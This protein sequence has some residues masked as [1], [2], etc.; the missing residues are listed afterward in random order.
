MQG[1]LYEAGAA[2]QKASSA[3]APAP[4]PLVTELTFFASIA[5]L[6]QA[7]SANDVDS[8]TPHLT[9]VRAGLN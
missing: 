6:Y 7:Q 5:N 4:V 1:V 8:M 2:L 9:E 3:E